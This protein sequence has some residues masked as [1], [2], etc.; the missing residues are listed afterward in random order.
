M[1]E[2]EQLHFQHFIQNHLLA[3]VVGGHAHDVGDAV[4]LVVAK[5]AKGVAKRD[6]SGENEV[7]VT[8][9]LEGQAVVVGVEKVIIAFIQAVG[10]LCP[11]YQVENLYHF[12]P[13]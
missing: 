2:T 13:L 1:W 12:I 4:I 5:L 11:V 6:V 7:D 9:L 10:H 3:D 8:R